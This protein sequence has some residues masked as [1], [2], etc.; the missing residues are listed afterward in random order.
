MGVSSSETRRELMP[1]VRLL[2]ADRL[3]ALEAPFGWA[4]CRLLTTGVLSRLSLA[5][6]GLYLA[7]C[8]AADRGGL[9]YWGDRR[10]CEGVGLEEVEL[11]RARR[12]LVKHDL[13][14]FDGRVYQ[15]LSLPG[16]RSE[17]PRDKPR[18]GDRRR[19]ELPSG[20]PRSSSPESLAE[21]LRRLRSPNEGQGERAGEAD[22]GGGGE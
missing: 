21:I 19:V 22:D 12:E 8:L 2:R 10:L 16:R 6:K 11:D 4:P 14:A 9:S 13:V 3:R 20:R 7:L 17:P 15:V 5:A 1:R 18:R